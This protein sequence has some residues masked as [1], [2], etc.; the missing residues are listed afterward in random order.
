MS[1]LFSPIKVKHYEFQNRIVMPPM[2]SEKATEAGAVTDKTI[3]YYVERA[4]EKLGAV[5][6]EHNFISENGRFSRRQLSVADNGKIPGLAKLANQIKAYGAVA[7]LQISHAGALALN[8]ETESPFSP[9]GIPT[10]RKKDI[11][12]RVM[13]YGDIAQVKAD[14]IKAAERAVESGFDGVEIHGAH[15]YLLNQFNSPV[16]NVRQDQYGG[17]REKRAR[18]SLE[19]AEAV[20]TVLKDRLLLF[21]LGAVDQ[22]EGGL[23]T[24]D[25]VWIARELSRKGVDIMDI[26]GGLGGYK[27]TKNSEGHFVPVAAEIKQNLTIPV[28]VTGGITSANYA[29]KV[30]AE[31]GLDFVG[32]G[33]ALL[34]RPDWP[35]LA[36]EKLLGPQLGQ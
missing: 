2:A 1:M 26:S 14:F 20:K 6:V 33:R 24:P 10:P 5:I 27:A 12:P 31:K 23:T 25:A 3:A 19:V 18:L 7:I 21:R 8:W 4:Q 11:H 34:S 29:E 35:S 13:S 15:G 32:I 30:V 17:S 9:S 16:T 28:I 22:Y 36:R